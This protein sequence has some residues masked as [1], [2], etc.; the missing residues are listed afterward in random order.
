[1]IFQV[2]EKEVLKKYIEAGKIAKSVLDYAEKLVLKEKCLSVLELAEKI[3][4]K[5][6]ELGAEPAFPVNISIN[7]IA[8]HFTPELHDKELVIKETDYVKIDVGVHIQGYIADTARTIRIAGEDELII[9]AREML[10]EA[11]KI[12]RPGVEVSEIGKAISEVA[13]SYGLKPIRNLTGHG[14]ERYKLHTGISIPNVPFG[15]GVLEEDKAYA[16]EPFCTNGYGAIKDSDRATIFMVLEDRP[17]RNPAARKVLDLTRKYNGL[18]FAKR[19][20]QKQIPQTT[21]ELALKQLVEAKVI[22]AFYILKEV[23]HGNVA[24]FEHTVVFDGDKAIITTR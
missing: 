20:L 3:E 17:L 21:L 5:I 15:K 8:A 2:M 22:H 24:Q 4:A 6:F 19:W 13:E 1:M 18:P 14:L 9:C 23:A 7:E 10:E 16:I 11:L 12:A